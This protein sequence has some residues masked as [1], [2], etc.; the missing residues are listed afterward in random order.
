MEKAKICINHLKNQLTRIKTSRYAAWGV[1]SVAGALTPFAFA[2][3]R[4]FW[5]MPVLFG[6][7]VLFTVLQEKRAVWLAFL[8]GFAAYLTQNYWVNISLH[9]VAELPQIYALPMT[10]LFPFYLALYP[11]LC[12][13]LLEK[14][15][16]SK[17]L[18]LTLALPL[19]W[20]LSEYVRQIALTGF[21][22]G[23]LGYSQI[24]NSPLAGFAPVGGVYLVTLAVACVSAWAVWA[25]TTSCF[26][27]RVTAIAMTVLLFALGAHLQSIEFTEPDGSETQVALIQGNVPQTLKFDSGRISQDI[28]MYYDQVAR[29]HDVDIAIL[30]E[31][32]IPLIRQTLPEGVI[33]QF[34]S[35]A[36][37]NN[38]A[39]AMG[40]IQ[41]TPEQDGYENAVINLEAFNPEAPDDIPYYAKNHLVPFGE[42]RPLPILTGWLYKLMNMPLSDFSRGGTDQAPLELANQKVAFN[43]CYEDSFGDELIDSAKQSSLLANVSNMGWF[44]SSNAMDIQLQHSQ[45]RA[46]ELGRYMVRATNNGMTAAIAPNGRI[47]ALIPRDTEQTLV[48][49]VYGYHGETPYMRMGGTW[50][51]VALIFVVLAALFSVGRV[52]RTTHNN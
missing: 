52:W 41:Y 37:R 2:P 49:T 45:A 14:L 28:Q 24:A 42:F 30:P 21:G 23:A 44:G 8:W 12:F 18:R 4:L 39:L 11:A 13:W 35:T 1:V 51:L 50:P 15:R 29:L 6:V 20:V 7:L 27:Q 36:K 46:L 47:T 10:L 34:A 5:L 22:W 25:L 32:A 48:T 3:Y 19:L 26:R 40:I 31:S 43:V 16:I 17:T 38:I 9:D 33:A